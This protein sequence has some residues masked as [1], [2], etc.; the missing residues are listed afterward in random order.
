MIDHE[1]WPFCIGC[2]ADLIFEDCGICDDGY[3]HP[4]ELYDEDPLWYEEDDIERCY[5]CD[6]D[7]GWW[8]CPNRDCIQ[9][10]DSHLRGRLATR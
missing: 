4:G 8:L 2:G 3:T 1:A 6:G 10:V 5:Q 9:T 7:G